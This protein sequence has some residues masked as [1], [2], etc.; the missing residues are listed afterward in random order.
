MELNEILK[1]IRLKIARSDFSGARELLLGS[2]GIGENAEAQALGARL[3][4]FTDGF[5]KANSMFLDLEAV[6]PDNFEVHKMHCQ[7][8]QEHGDY[9]G[10]V[11]AAGKIIARFATRADAYEILAD[12]LELAGRPAEA[13][14]AVTEGLAGFPGL[15][16]LIERQAR[17]TAVVNRADISS[18]GLEE[19]KNELTSQ[20]VLPTEENVQLLMTMFKG[21]TGV[22]AVQTRMGK[23]W[24]YIPEKREM[25]AEDLRKHLGGEKTLG[26]YLTDLNN[27]SRLMVMDLDVRKA[28]LNAYGNSP[29]ER[30]RINGLIKNSCD[31]MSEVCQMAGLEPLI[32]TSGNKGLHFWFFGGD[33]F[34]CRYW[35]SL[36]NW[37]VSKLRNIPEELSWE[38]FP[39]QDRVA[40]D[41]LGNLVKLPLGTHQKTGRKSYFVDRQTLQPFPEQISV[42][43]Q[44]ARICRG[45]FEKILGAI[46]V[47]NCA[48]TGT[49][50]E[51][52]GGNAVEFKPFRAAGDTG[53]SM[54]EAAKNYENL[55][56]AVR[57]PLP[58]RH[59]LEIEKLLAG[60]RPMWEILEKARY[61]KALSEE[62]KHAFIYIF[63]HLGEEGRVFIHQ[64]MNQLPDYQPDAV[65]AMIRAV[66]PNAPG[67]GRIRKRIPELCGVDRCNCQF[68][69]PAGSYAS[70][71]IHAGIF[72][73]TGAGKVCEIAPASLSGREAIG[74]ES[75][76]IDRMMQ[77]YMQMTEDLTRLRERA[78]LLRRQINQLFN[79]A[80]SDRIETRIR[81][82]QRLPDEETP[83]LT[84]G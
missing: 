64:V 62:Q 49:I 25:T 21:R 33:D 58:E 63:A 54:A 80:G 82:Y 70:P 5:E 73:G 44:A 22:H 10:S 1:Q 18:N 11:L 59:T 19:I 79:E 42:L 69:L 67:C 84:V 56:L 27:T 75:G 35:R 7:L 50:A 81:V 9:N 12:S 36:G 26:I 38:V 76:G 43:R 83:M 16:P 74:G 3:L 32:E 71:V 14:Q 41:G 60:C 47:D 23:S 72:P 4:G 13:L 65:N 46:T 52:Q 28:W 37:L 30:K 61:E 31:Q 39:K 2:A 51:K 68:R 8:L 40:A 17:L 48:D 53:G 20:P 34:A 78:S 45:D 57:I 55:N 66:P 6:W 77:E 15:G 29:E 24:G